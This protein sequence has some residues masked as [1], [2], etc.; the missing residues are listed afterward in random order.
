MPLQLVKTAPRE[1]VALIQGIQQHLVPGIM[2]EGD[3]SDDICRFTALFSTPSPLSTRD[4]AG[5]QNCDSG[6]ASTS[7]RVPLTTQHT[8][9]L[10]GRI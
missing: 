1:S 3:D 4:L 10:R 8:T 5:V 9:A 6:R 2:I 7:W